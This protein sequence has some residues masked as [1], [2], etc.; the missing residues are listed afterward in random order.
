MKISAADCKCLSSAK[1]EQTTCSWCLADKSLRI[2]HDEEWGLP[3]YDDGVLFEH[4]ALEI[5]QGGLNWRLILNKRDILRHAL[6]RF[7]PDSLALF[8]E[9]DIESA[10]AVPGMIHSR[11]K[12]EAIIHNARILPEM[13]KQH[14][15]FHDWLWRFTNGRMLVYKS[16]AHQLPPKNNLSDTISAELKKRGFRH[17]G[18]ITVYSMLQACGIINDHSPMCPRFHEV[19]NGMDITFLND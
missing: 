9:K 12:I 19:M 16:H 8:T 1:I 17:I 15:S 2:Y 13:Q 18:S 5:M 4:L 10:L 14:G 11:R 6:A 3:A 7:T